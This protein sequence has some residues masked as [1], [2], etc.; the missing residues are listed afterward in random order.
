M[1]ARTLEVIS[2]SV[3]DDVVVRAGREPHRYRIVGEVVLPGIDDPGALADTALFTRP[4]LDRVHG[5]DDGYLLVRLQ[6]GVDAGS[7][8]RR[9][10]D[11]SGEFGAVHP[12]VPAEIDRLRQIDLLPAA[13]AAFVGVVALCC[14]SSKTSV[15]S[16]RAWLCQSWHVLRTILRNQARLLPPENVGKYRNA[17]KQASCTTSSASSSFAISHRANRYAASR[18]G[19]TTVSNVAESRAVSVGL[20]M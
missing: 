7:A 18:C 19:R 20:F 2:R 15:A 4:G 6:P 1:G 11:F 9:L 5:T 16:C 14:S 8:A 17:R 13:L 3:G 12:Q 10:A